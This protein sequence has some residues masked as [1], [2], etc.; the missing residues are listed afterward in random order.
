MSIIT[1]DGIAPEYNKPITSQDALATAADTVPTR[2]PIDTPEEELCQSPQEIVGSNQFKAIF[3]RWK[4]N[5]EPLVL[6]LPILQDIIHNKNVPRWVDR[7]KLRQDLQSLFNHWTTFS[8]RYGIMKS[9]DTE[10]ATTK[11]IE[12]FRTLKQSLYQMFGAI[13]Q[14]VGTKKNPFHFENKSVFLDPTHE[15]V[16]E[17]SHFND[18]DKERIQTG[19]E[20]LDTI[21]REVPVVTDVIPLINQII[22]T[23]DSNKRKGRFKY[24][25]HKPEIKAL[26]DSIVPGDYLALPLRTGVTNTLAIFNKRTFL[27][28]LVTCSQQF[29]VAKNFHGLTFDNI[30]FLGVSHETITENSL[31]DRFYYTHQPVGGKRVHVGFLSD[32]LTTDTD[33]G[34]RYHAYAKKCISEMANTEALLREG[35]TILP[36]HGACV[37]IQLEKGGEWIGL[38]F[39]GE[40]STGKGEMIEQLTRMKKAG[41]IVDL[42]IVAGDM[43]HMRKKKRWMVRHSCR[44][45]RLWQHVKCRLKNDGR[46]C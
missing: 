6:N 3:S 24:E 16:I 8:I 38:A 7:T 14:A 4:K 21:V 32:K 43:F 44:A 33:P 40:S 41:S 39:A 11:N 17:Y 20:K 42:R 37:Q 29:M 13:E 18:Q 31:N 34:H 22:F 2:E 36:V 23:T 35:E 5:Y 12:K 19:D 26:L 9:Q 30:L 1:N 45:R 27:E 15:F 25:E 10:Q 28:Q 46:V